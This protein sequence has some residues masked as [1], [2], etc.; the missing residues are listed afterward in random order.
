MKQI[1]QMLK[2]L[3][4]IKNYVIVF[5]DQANNS[6]IIFIDFSDV[7]FANDLNI[8]QSFNDYCFKLFDDMID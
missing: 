4:H 2:Y 7:S 8:R 5:N 6:N 1:N 3:T